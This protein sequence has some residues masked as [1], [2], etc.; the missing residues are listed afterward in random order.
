MIKL[1]NEN[2][3][4]KHLIK[5]AVLL[6]K[7]KK[8]ENDLNKHLIKGAVLL[9]KTKRGELISKEIILDFDK[10]QFL[11]NWKFEHKSFLLDRGPRSFNSIEEFF[12]TEIDLELSYSV[13]RIC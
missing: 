11:E 13:W 1:E 4:N 6:F 8:N 9:F 10:K 3:L 7:T 5:G 2:D 12:I